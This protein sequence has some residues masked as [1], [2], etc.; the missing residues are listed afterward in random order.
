MAEPKA[1]LMLLLIFLAILARKTTKNNKIKYE[2][3]DGI[4]IPIR[5]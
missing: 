2:I 1:V 5:Q 4:K 3:Y